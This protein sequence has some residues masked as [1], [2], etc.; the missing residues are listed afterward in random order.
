MNTTDR[1]IFDSIVCEDDIVRE[2][3]N[4]DSILSRE[5]SLLTYRGNSDKVNIISSRAIEL[6][7]NPTNE[8]NKLY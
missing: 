4:H 6:T 5:V 1:G 2:T 8:S 3:T 7:I